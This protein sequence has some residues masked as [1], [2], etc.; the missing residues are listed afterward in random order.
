MNN[1]RQIVA[2]FLATA[3]LVPNI[4]Y[5]VAAIRTNIPVKATTTQNFCTNVT[6]YAARITEALTKNKANLENRQEKNKENFQE[7]YAKRSQTLTQARVLGDADREEIYTKLMA[8]ATTDAQ[9]QAVQQFKATVETAVTARRSAVDVAVKAYWD[10]LDASLN[11]RQ[12]SV[13]SAK[14]TFTNAI[15]TAVAAAQSACAGGTDPATV[16]TQFNATVKAAKTQ[17]ST[18]RKAIDKYGPQ[19]KAIVTTRNAEVKKAFDAF[20]ATMEQARTALKASLGA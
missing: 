13:D 3:V 7:R 19:V 8:K 2:V 4:S 1:K 6:S 20:R 14:Q 15:N 12:S 16:R 11:G 18:D 10:A 5:A 17:F 9:K